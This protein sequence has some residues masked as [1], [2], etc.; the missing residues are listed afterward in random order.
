[1][2]KNY[3]YA[4]AT[5][6]GTVVGAGIFALP[7]V[8]SQSG[9]VTLF[10]FL[11]L[12]VLIQY[13][14]HKMYAE[15]VLSTRTEHRIPGYTEIYAG[16][17]YKSLASVFSIISAYGALLA[18]I[19]LGGIFLHGLF[20]STLGGTPF[21]YSIILFSLESM[22]V[23]FGL[24]MIASAEL[25]MTV[26]LVAVVLVITT[27]SSAFINPGNF[28][29]IDWGKFFLPYGPIFFSIGG[30]AAI[31]TVCRLLKKEKR[32]IKSAIFWGTLIPAIITI[33]FVSVIVGVTGFATTPDTLVGLKQVFSNGIVT[34]ALIFGLLS[35]ITSFL[36]ISQAVREV[37]WWDFKMNKNFAWLI[38]CGVPLLLFFLGIHN[39]TKVV[40]FT[41]AISGGVGGIILIY[42]TF[43]VQTKAQKK[44]VIK[45]RISK[46]VAF[47]LSSLFVL[48]LIN[49]IIKLLN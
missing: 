1:M 27:K 9:I 30:L 42:L 48:G 3:F 15:V 49:E 41:G 5:L 46:W 8:I 38:A 13:Y 19:I 4:I 10:I 31:P 7:F 24:K 20:G 40:S 23:F 32:K 16:K 28:I 12:L 35:V 36:V 22:I 11:P 21:V 17:K 29:L 45:T 37:Y 18:Y 44:S 2:S 47:V 43:K 14:L 34:F 26:F 25:F 39:L 6:I 33:V